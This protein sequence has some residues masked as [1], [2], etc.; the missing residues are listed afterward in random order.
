[1]VLPRLECPSRFLYRYAYPQ[2]L[3]FNCTYHQWM[4]PLF[5]EAS[6]GNAHQLPFLLL[7]TLFDVPV[8]VDEMRH[9]VLEPATLQLISLRQVIPN[10][11][12]MEE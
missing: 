6:D 1:M 11:I 9:R 3:Y 5:V 2:H 10:T 12:T 8:W 7:F 4:S